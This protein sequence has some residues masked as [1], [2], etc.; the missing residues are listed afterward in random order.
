MSLE[1][2]WLET[3]MALGLKAPPGAFDDVITRY[4]E[5]HRAYHTLQHLSECL[6]HLAALKDTLSQSQRANIAL[7]LWYHDAVYDTHRSD[8]EE[9]SARLAD[10]NLRAAGAGSD[11]RQHIHSLILATKHNFTSTEFEVS[12]L[13]DIDLAI[14]GAS[15]ERFDEYERQ[16]R[17]EYAWVPDADFRAGRSRILDCFLQRPAIYLTDHFRARFEV[18]ARSNLR[19]S[20]ESL[21]FQE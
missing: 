4:S 20:I 15:V 18:S 12:T 19:R 6:K 5:L 9:L 17:Q 13:V 7:A 2:D 8:N 10:E 3:W 1:V 11:L 21:T 14:L 16:V